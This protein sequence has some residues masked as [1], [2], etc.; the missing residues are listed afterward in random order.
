MRIPTRLLSANCR[1][2][3][4]RHHPASGLASAVLGEVFTLRI[5]L[6]GLAG[7]DATLLLLRAVVAARLHTGWPAAR[8]G[9]AD[10]S[11]AAVGFLPTAVI[12]LRFW[13]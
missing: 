1:Q 6:L 9:G 11:L 3:F 10:A 4:G 8:R 13:Q 5:R 2:L 7:E 12:P